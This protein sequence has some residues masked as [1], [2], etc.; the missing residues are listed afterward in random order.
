MVPD[1]LV[2]GSDVRGNYAC[3]CVV[4]AWIGAHD[5]VPISPTPGGCVT[6]SRSMP[7]ARH[8]LDRLRAPRRN[9]PVHRPSGPR[10]SATVPSPS[11][12]RLD[13]VRPA[14]LLP[15]CRP[16]SER[17]PSA[18]RHMPA[19]RYGCGLGRPV[20]VA[21]RNASTASA[22]SRTRPSVPEQQHVIHEE[23]GRQ[24]HGQLL[25]GHGECP[26]GPVR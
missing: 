17:R 3:A 14:A 6:A 18:V 2:A 22:R 5:G 1:L 24:H 11:S 13:A 12:G 4:V 8:R 23:H 15:E 21:S 19:L 7:A 10:S 16:A 25:R 26:R 9:N 20:A